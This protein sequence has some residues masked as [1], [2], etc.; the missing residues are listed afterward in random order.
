MNGFT[1]HPHISFNSKGDNQYEDP[2]N[3]I[4]RENLKYA[5]IDLTD[6]T[7]YDSYIT[8]STIP[9]VAAG[10]LSSILD[11]LLLGCNF[12]EL[13]QLDFINY[14]IPAYAA[15]LVAAIKNWLELA[16]Y[17]ATVLPDQLKQG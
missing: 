9:Y 15:V 11:E 6:L 10:Y 16:R 14:R 4:I 13:E 17:Y 1:F 2:V 5:A 3:F 7:L 12:S 8:E